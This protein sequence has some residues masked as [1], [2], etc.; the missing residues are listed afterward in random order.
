MIALVAA[1]TTVHAASDEGA[2]VEIDRVESSDARGDAVPGHGQQA[3]EANLFRVAV[4][5][6]CDIDVRVGLNV[7][8]Q[9]GWWSHTEGAYF[10]IAAGSGLQRNYSMRATAN[11]AQASHHELT[12]R[13]IGPDCDAGRCHTN[14]VS[15]SVTIHIPEAID[16][17]SQPTDCL[18]V[19]GIFDSEGNMKV[20]LG[21]RCP[22]AVGV[23]LEAVDSSEDRLQFAILEVD[24]AAG[25]PLQDF[26]ITPWVD[27]DLRLTGERWV[28]LELSAAGCAECSP[29]VTERPYWAQRIDIGD[30]PPEPADEPVVV[31]PTSNQSGAPN[32]TAAANIGAGDGGWYS[33]EEGAVRAS[34]GLTSALLLVLAYAAV[35]A[36]A[37]ATMGFGQALLVAL[38]TGRGRRRRFAEHVD[39]VTRI[40]LR[41][42]GDPGFTAKQLA[43]IAEIPLP[44]A[45]PMIRRLVQTGW[46]R[47]G[48]GDEEDR[49]YHRSCLTREQLAEHGLGEH[50]RYPF[51]AHRVLTNHLLPGLRT[52][53]DPK[54][55]RVTDLMEWRRWATREF[56]EGV[57]EE[58]LEAGLATRVVIDGLEDFELVP[59]AVE[60]FEIR[61][62]A[63]LHGFESEEGQS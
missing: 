7:E 33:V 42:W 40:L 31:P 23:S 28:R 46:L 45:M 62:S 24:L 52:K 12:A 48:T 8:A 25:G 51:D 50:W 47:W 35:R 16:E 44:R 60:L 39:D 53:L 41:S 57:I 49:L 13:L 26:D 37:V 21:N 63:P 6:Y 27:G 11:A 15:T 5:N 54:E 14:T 55:D 61:P 56:V 36:R 18:W 22:T 43:E 38:S 3:G 4:I 1:G 2:C 59:E 10:D 17:P 20:T 58:L 9:E 30:A 19:G 29:I 32:G 34:V